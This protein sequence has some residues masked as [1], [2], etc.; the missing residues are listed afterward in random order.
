[1]GIQ[2]GSNHTETP[3]TA[4]TTEPQGSHNPV[5]LPRGVLH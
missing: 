5:W 1:M 2:N 4:L 3:Q